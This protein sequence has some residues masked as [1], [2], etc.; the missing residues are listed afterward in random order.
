MPSSASVLPLSVLAANSPPLGWFEKLRESESAFGMVSSTFAMSC[1]ASSVGCSSK[2]KLPSFE[3][4]RTI[5][6]S[7]WI[8]WKN[9]AED[10]SDARRMMNYGDDCASLGGS[11][12]R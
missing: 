2:R 1:D 3:R 4:T 9:E 11:L 8:R 7:K 12:Y 10:A 6:V 5:M